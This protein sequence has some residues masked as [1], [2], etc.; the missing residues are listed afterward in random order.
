MGWAESIQGW[1][2]V[3]ESDSPAAI[4]GYHLGKGTSERV[5]EFSLNP[6]PTRV[7]MD[8]V[9]HC[10]TVRKVWRVRQTAVPVVEGLSDAGQFAFQS[11]YVQASLRFI[12]GY[13]YLDRCGEALVKLENVLEKGWLPAESAPK[14]GA[15]RNDQLGMTSTF[16]SE[17]MTVQQT[18]PVS[19]ELFL[20]QVCKI[21][22]T[23][24]QILK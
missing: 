21:F 7:S 13:R 15:L 1:S 24:W 20:D 5:A 8:P 6:S 14:A 17:G 3:S 2:S 12:Q 16:N 19:F 18:A 11:A 4:R 10:K 22:D 9:R 23:L